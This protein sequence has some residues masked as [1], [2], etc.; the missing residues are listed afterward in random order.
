[1]FGVQ[2]RDAMIESTQLAMRV[3]QLAVEGV[4]CVC[5]CRT[6]RMQLAQQ[7]F[8]TRLKILVLQKQAHPVEYAHMPTPCVSCLHYV[9]VG[10]GH[11][12]QMC[13]IKDRVPILGAQLQRGGRWA[14]GCGT[15]K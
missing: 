9:R 5:S 10:L 3:L 1:M 7:E 13:C 14:V 2:A 4:Q 8:S 12:L 11:K 15:P 6:P